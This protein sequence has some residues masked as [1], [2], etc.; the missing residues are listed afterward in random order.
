MSVIYIFAQS[1]NKRDV[2]D[3]IHENKYDTVLI[4]LNPSETQVCEPYFYSMGL[5]VTP[6]I[7]TIIN[8][9]L[10]N[11]IINVILIG[12]N[13]EF[14]IGLLSYLTI[15][16]NE[17]NIKIDSEIQMSE[18]NQIEAEIVVN[19]IK[20]TYPDEGF[21]INTLN[22]NYNIE[23]IKELNTQ[24]ININN[25]IIFNVHLSELDVKEYGGNYNVFFKYY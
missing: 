4:S 25:Y 15:R 7:E 5:S 14:S 24:S 16:L 8:Y 2:Y 6:L 10:E 11:K 21:L 1:K 9:I 23:F 20:E 3:Y 17:N 13:E 12:Y 19:S 18:A 22:F